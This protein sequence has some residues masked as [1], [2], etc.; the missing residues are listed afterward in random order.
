[1]DNSLISRYFTL[2]SLK[3]SSES[4]EQKSPRFPGCRKQD[5]VDGVRGCR[6]Y[7]SRYADDKL[8]SHLKIA[9]T[10]Q[11]ILASKRTLSLTLET[12]F[13]FPLSGKLF[14]LPCSFQD[15]VLF[16]CF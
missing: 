5:S 1:V 9:E 13:G 7:E 3:E 4:S 12:F 14:G 10:Q 2:V 6:A 8:P 15:G 16:L 11:A